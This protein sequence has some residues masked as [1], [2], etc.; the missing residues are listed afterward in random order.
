[1]DD[2]GNL[3]VPELSSPLQSEPDRMP[4]QINEPMTS[5]DN[6]YVIADYQEL[7]QRR[8]NRLSDSTAPPLGREALPDLENPFCADDK[9]SIALAGFSG[10][11]DTTDRVPYYRERRPFEAGLKNAPGDTG[12][13]SPSRRIS[14]IQHITGKTLCCDIDDVEAVQRG[15]WRPKPLRQPR[16]SRTDLH[17]GTD[18]SS[19]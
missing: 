13:L 8:G 7:Q 2:G 12:K 19:V 10:G 9:A 16:L 15:R 5:T 3:P 1:M 18:S 6:S 14:G 11:G 17:K 4:M